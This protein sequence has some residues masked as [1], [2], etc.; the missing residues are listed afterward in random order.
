MPVADIVNIINDLKCF[1]LVAFRIAGLVMIA[2]F[3]SHRAIPRNVK[4][5]LTVAVAVVI[6][7][8][9]N[10]LGLR[11]PD[12]MGGY[13]AVAVTEMAVGAIIG[14][15]VLLVFS[16]VQLGGFIADQQIGL[17]IAQ[18]FNP[19]S[20]EESSLLADLL[21]MVAVTIFILV[22]GHRLLLRVLAVSYDTVPLARADF[23]H[24]VAEKLSIG[25]VS[26]MFASA[27]KISAPAVIALM[28]ATIVMAIVART[29]PEMNIFN[30]GFALRLGL[31][32]IIVALSLPA[33][34]WILQ[35]MFARMTGDLET[36]VQALRPGS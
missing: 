36:L 13:F 8:T 30:I 14:F 28:L 26:Q 29:V 25:M 12:N 1:V 34:G 17:A 15:G 23:A 11:V 19:D 32:L 24:G 33:L 5:A 2:P 35:T 18:V 3:F 16:A 9:V 22:G 7:P 6:F 10:R 20:G 21:Y 31:G 27:V 4:V